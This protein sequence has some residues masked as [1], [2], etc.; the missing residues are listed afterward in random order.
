M[1]GILNIFKPTGVTSRDCVNII[2]RIT[3]PE[4]VGHA[5]TLDPMAQG[6]LL[7]A[8]GQA[9]RLVDWMH[10]LPKSYVAEFEL[11]KTSESADTETPVS[12]LENCKTPSFEELQTAS[13]QFKGRIQQTPPTYSAV[14]IGGKRAYNLARKGVEVIVPPRQVEVHRLDILEYSPPNFKLHVQCG[15]G[16]YMRSLGRDLARVVNS[17]AIMTALLR[18]QVGPFDSQCAVPIQSLNSN[19]D[20]L[21]HIQPPGNA[22]PHVPRVELNEQEMGRIMQGQPVSI[23]TPFPKH[24][25]VAAFDRDGHLRSLLSHRSGDL[26]GPFRNFIQV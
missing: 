4:K 11:G 22:I 23:A 7:V 25:Q 26:W 8:I 20:V 24:S 5:G 2:Q 17:D 1:F 13:L 19:E 12:I 15:S 16:T 9:V 6:V 21:K 14:K 18:T 3:R 10:E